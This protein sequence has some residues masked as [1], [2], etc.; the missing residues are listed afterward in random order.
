MQ[1]N[2]DF[3]W[4][5]EKKET[6]GEAGLHFWQYMTHLTY[7]SYIHIC[8]VYFISFVYIYLACRLNN[9]EKL[10][11]FARFSFTCDSY[12][13]ADMYQAR[14]TSRDV[15]DIRLE[16]VTRRA[17]NPTSCRN[18]LN[19]EYTCVNVYDR[20]RL[21]NRFY[22]FVFTIALIAFRQKL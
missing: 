18:P 22:L 19:Y 21:E 14:I 3:W 15:M 6:P 8:F 2:I 12:I 1:A 20:V 9:W 17:V 16:N 5:M 10:F 11:L 7:L 13:C 4:G